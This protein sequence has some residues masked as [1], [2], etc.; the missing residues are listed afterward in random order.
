MWQMLAALNQKF[1]PNKVVLTIVT[2][3]GKLGISN[4]ASFAEDFSSIDGKSTA[5]VCS[6]FQ[7]ELPTTDVKKMLSLLGED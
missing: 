3:K 4:I 2:D 7:C 6:N 5:Y 1:I